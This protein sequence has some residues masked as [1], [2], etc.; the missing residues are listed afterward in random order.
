MSS[1]LKPRSHN[2]L[3]TSVHRPP[4]SVPRLTLIPCTMTT[5][6]SLVSRRD[7]PSGDL[8]A[9][10]R[11][12]KGDGFEGEPDRCGGAADGCTLWGGKKIGGNSGA[13][14]V[15]EEERESYPKP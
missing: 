12:G 1:T 5:A 7:P 14:P 10:H 13:A 15:D 4:N 11:R 6:R 3:A 9:V 2:P 8:D